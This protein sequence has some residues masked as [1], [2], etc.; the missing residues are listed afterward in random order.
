MKFKKIL[1]NDWRQ[2]QNIDID[3][4]PNVTIIT[5][6]NGSG[7]STILK[8]LSKH[9]GWYQPFLGTPIL[10]K[11]QGVFYYKT[12][13]RPLNKEYQTSHYGHNIHILGNIFYSNDASS[14]IFIHEQIY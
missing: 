9:F 7:K 13:F 5:G 14:D 12:V 1:L 2:F 11:E 3:F 8:L 10:S 4:H 6:A